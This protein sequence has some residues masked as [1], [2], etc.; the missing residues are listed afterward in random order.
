[1]HR[2]ETAPSLFLNDSV[3]VSAAKTST[4]NHIDVIAVVLN[5]LTV[6]LGIPGNS[7]VIWVAGCKPKSV[8]Y[9]FLFSG[10]P[11]FAFLLH[12]NFSFFFFFSL[13]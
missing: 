10:Y 5:T 11:K 4:E 2:R 1:M 13:V 7:L 9:L 12:Y 8:E 6:V 3:S